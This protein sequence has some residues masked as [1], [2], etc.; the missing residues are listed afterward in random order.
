MRL[1][2]GTAILSAVAVLTLA[3]PR[4]VLDTVA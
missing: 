3:V 4:L 1:G 2:K